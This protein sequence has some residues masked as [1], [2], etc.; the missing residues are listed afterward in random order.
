MK[1]SPQLGMVRTVCYCHV[2]VILWVEMDF[3]LVILYSVCYNIRYEVIR[4]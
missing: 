1:I 3:I 2:C 4:L